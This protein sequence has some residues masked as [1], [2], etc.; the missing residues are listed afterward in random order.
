D[1]GPRCLSS[2][3]GERWRFR[4]GGLSPYRGGECRGGISCLLELGGLSYLL[5]GR[6][7]LDLVVLRLLS[8]VGDLRG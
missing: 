7:D 5:R 4:R 6:G 3:F 2:S 1:K 8:G